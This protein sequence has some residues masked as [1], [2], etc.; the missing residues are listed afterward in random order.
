MIF[1]LSWLVKLSYVF[2]FLHQKNEKRPPLLRMACLDRHA[3]LSRNQT[4]FPQRNQ[5]RID[6]GG[7]FRTCGRVA[8]VGNCSSLINRGCAVECQQVSGCT[9]KLNAIGRVAIEQVVG[10]LG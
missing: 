10:G 6:S 4:L 1:L 8:K 2:Q 9:G 7:N 3:G 5:D